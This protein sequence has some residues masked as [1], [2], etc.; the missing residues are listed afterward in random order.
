MP[1]AAALLF[2]QGMLNTVRAYLEYVG[3]ENADPES[4]NEGA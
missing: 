2:L 3:D 1:L 4:Q